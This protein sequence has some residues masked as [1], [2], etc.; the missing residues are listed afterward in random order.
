MYAAI[1]SDFAAREG[2]GDGATFFELGYW[3]RRKPSRAYSPAVF[4]ARRGEYWVYTFATSIPASLP[5]FIK[6][7]ADVR[8]SA[9]SGWFRS[10]RNSPGMIAGAVGGTELMV[11]RKKGLIAVERQIKKALNCV[12]C[13]ACVH[14]C[15]QGAISIRDDSIRVS[16]EKCRR[17]GKCLLVEKCIALKYRSQREWIVDQV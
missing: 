13:G 15:P 6:P 3:K 1:V 17:C 9:S 16:Q 4:R 11:Y 7:L 12:K 14:V 5:E 2:K 10:C 8:L